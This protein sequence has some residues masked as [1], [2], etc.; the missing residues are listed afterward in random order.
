MV[1]VGKEEYIWV[2][3][4]RVKENNK[5]EEEEEESEGGGLSVRDI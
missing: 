5:E 1:E 4:G 3:F 2:E